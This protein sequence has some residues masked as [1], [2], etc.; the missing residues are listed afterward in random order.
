MSKFVA[1]TVKQTHQVLSAGQKK[2]PSILNTAYLQTYTEVA[3]GINPSLIVSCKA[4]HESDNADVSAHIETREGMVNLPQLSIVQKPKCES[5][6]EKTQAQVKTSIQSLLP[7][8][9]LPST[10]PL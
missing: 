4:V 3:L 1:K 6:A 8:M 2:P 5:D 10:S 7:S 9:H